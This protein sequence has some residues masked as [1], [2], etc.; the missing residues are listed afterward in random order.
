ME[1]NKEFDSIVKIELTYKA[2]EIKAS[3]NSLR[4]IFLKIEKRQE[5]G[6]IHI[7]FRKLAAVACIA[8]TLFTA[9]F[10]VSA[11]ARVL[12]ANL[13]DN[14]K[15]VFVIDKNNN[16]VERPASEV[17]INPGI[18]QMT[19]LNDEELS[20]KMG[21]KIRIPQT[22]YGE[23]NLQN[24]FDIVAFNKTLSYETF[25]KIKE[26]ADKAI[27][28]KDAFQSLKEYKPY[29]SVGCTFKDSKGASV[30]ICI[31]DTIIHISTR[32]DDVSEIVKTKVGQINAEWIG[33]SYTDYNRGDMTQKPV[34]KKSVHTLFWSTNNSTYMI[35]PS[36]SLSMDET[37][38]IA[39]AFMKT[40]N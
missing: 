5:R 20:Q 37:I 21:I 19:T 29:R 28:D 36:Q 23:F 7:N 3:E 8:F 4:D 25:D 10:V 33:I 11:D 30:N 15:M 9:T 32:N 6:K 18:T 14:I 1:N 13:I 31:L 39:E 40:Q 2:N 16:V 26:I 38:K 22:F 35:L 27:N 24:K 34:G 12:A 17:F